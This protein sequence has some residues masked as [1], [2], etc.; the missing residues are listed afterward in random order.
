MEGDWRTREMSSPSDR[1]SRLRSDTH[2]RR[3]RLLPSSYC[4]D[5]PR[6]V[7]SPQDT[8]HAR[9]TRLAVL[10]ILLTAC[11]DALTI[12]VNGHATFLDVDH[13]IDIQRFGPGRLEDE[14]GTTIET[15]DGRTVPLRENAP[16]FFFRTHDGRVVPQHSL[17]S[18]SPAHA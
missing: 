16:Y 14:Y 18:E 10:C 5:C 11:P 12:T 1:P 3:P 15:R 13:Q 17:N 6:S 9:Y 7:R 8:P 2:Q 4:G